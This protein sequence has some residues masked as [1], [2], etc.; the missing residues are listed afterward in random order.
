MFF[1]SLLIMP[2]EASGAPRKNGKLEH[3]YP[4]S[5]QSIRDHGRNKLESDSSKPFYAICTPNPTIRIERLA[6]CR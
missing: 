6:D 3:N 5:I 1:W 4:K 2:S